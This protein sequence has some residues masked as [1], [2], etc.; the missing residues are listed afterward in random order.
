MKIIPLLADPS[1]PYNS[2]H[3][4]I[5]KSLAEVKS[6]VLLGD[7]PN[8]DALTTNLFTICFDVLSGPSKTDS[9]EELSKNVEHHM[10]SMLST[11]I[12]ESTQ[13]S[14]D[15]TDV[16]LAQFLRA[17]VT[18]LGAGSAKGKKVPT[19][20]ANQSTL[21]MKEA[22]PP[23]NMAKNIC[24]TCPDKM[25]RAI[26]SY[27]SNV[28]VD[29]TTGTGFRNRGRNRAGSE[30]GD[31]DAEVQTGPSEEDLNEAAK[32][33][34]LLRELWR[35]CPGVLQEIIPHLQEELGAENV[36]LRQ[37]ATE[38]FGD[39]ISGIGAAGPPPPPVLNPL[40]YPSQSLLPQSDTLRVYNF[41]TTPT[42]PNSF[43]MQHPAAYSAF[44]Q[45]KHDKSPI[46][47]ASWTTG[48]GRILMT[49]AGGVGLD[50]EE[51]KRLLRFY[52][53]MLIDG[54]DRVRLAALK[55]IEHF[56]FNAIVQKLGTIGGMS[57]PG[58]I[59]A[60]LADRVKDRKNVIRTE[61]MR[62]LGRIWGV[63]AG[64][65]AKGNER[66]NSL[67]GL[68][69]SRILEAQYVNDREISTQI[70]LTMF[71]SL[72]P[73]GYPPMKARAA[74]NGSSQK[75]SGANL[76]NTY[77]EADLDKIRAE[78]EL[79]LVRG[80]EEKAKKVFFAKQ[81]NQAAGAAYMDSFLKRCEEFNGGIM[82][83]DQEIIERNLTVLIK[84]Y[85]TTLPDA[86]RVIND[87]WSFAKAHDR[88]S[89]QLIR[90]CMAP[91]SDYRKVFRSIVSIPFEPVKAFSS[92]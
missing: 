18:A 42:S 39:M 56:E 55:A 80:L 5:L 23:Y 88:R 2:Q 38:T 11:L 61:S 54:D 36:N 6:I 20:D 33:H 22:P 43:P 65:I 45:R 74:L 26:G 73:L 86:H 79:V 10:T 89:Y 46:I 4:Y 53:D 30:G 41:L 87:L 77:T 91:D 83:K 12:D 13:V 31:S 40:A 78:R 8:S 62:I 82:G 85:S 68:I 34:R 57:E 24:N 28:I 52:A 48:I 67:L 16:I 49:S 29:A 84:Y 15:V 25:A 7:I 66:I 50:P 63:A 69:P 35:C 70:D 32:A 76:E 72:L 47:R 3:L 90:F 75:E 1:N 60:N 44:L 81:A 19:V 9:G 14:Q 27:F 59:L 51:E 92:Y 21:L 17:D 64:A 37:M 58:S 71:D